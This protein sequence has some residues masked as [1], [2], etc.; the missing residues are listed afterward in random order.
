MCVA[1]TGTDEADTDGRGHGLHQYQN[2]PGLVHPSTK[3][4]PYIQCPSFIP[5]YRH[6]FIPS[7]SA[8]PSSGSCIPCISVPYASILTNILKKKGIDPVDR[9][10]IHDRLPAYSPARPL[11]I[12]VIAQFLTRFLSTTFPTSSTLTD[13]LLHSLRHSLCHSLCHYPFDHPIHCSF[14]TT[15]GPSPAH[16]TPGEYG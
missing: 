14:P 3:R 9:V 6:V 8:I 16:S 15:L 4:A 1:D 10:M 11:F 7:L 12:H 2:Q 13:S 5:K